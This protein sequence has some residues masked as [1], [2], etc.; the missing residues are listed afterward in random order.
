[1][2]AAATK[3]APSKTGTRTVLMGKRTLRGA[4]A[5]PIVSVAGRMPTEIDAQKRR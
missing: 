1:M 2:H 3:D 5:T 4:S